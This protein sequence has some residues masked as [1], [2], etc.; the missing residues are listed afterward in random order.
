MAGLGD[1]IWSGTVLKLDSNG[2]KQWSYRTNNM[3]N[4]N[5]V[6][7]T[8]DGGYMAGLGDQVWSGT[9]L[10]LDSNGQKQWSYRTNNMCNVNSVAQT[11]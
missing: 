8:S 11:Y 1:Q 7:E 3:C 5:S 10:K 4:V 2:Q 9:V 6:I